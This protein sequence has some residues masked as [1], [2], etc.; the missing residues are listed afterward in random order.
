MQRMGMRRNLMGHLLGLTVIGLLA[1]QAA[2]AGVTMT[3]LGSFSI[4]GTKPASG[5]VG[6]YGDAVAFVPADQDSISQDTLIITWAQTDPVNSTRRLFLFHRITIVPKNNGTPNILCTATIPSDL[7]VTSGQSH[8][9]G[10]G[11]LAR[12]LVAWHRHDCP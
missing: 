1:V 6:Y 3:T 12:E 10:N 7:A 8:V 4:G 11:H 2:E 9:R 5:A